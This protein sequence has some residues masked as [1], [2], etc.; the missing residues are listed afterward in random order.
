MIL[1][2]ILAL[3]AIIL[4]IVTV[5]TVSTVGAGAIVIFGDV[6]VCIVFIVLIIRWMIK[7]KNDWVLTRALSFC[8]RKMHIILWKNRSGAT[9]MLGLN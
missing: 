8:S 1:F 5:V 6:I 3:T 9:R 7:K 4:T 2:T